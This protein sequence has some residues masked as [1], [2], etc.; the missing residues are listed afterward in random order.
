MMMMIII[1]IIIIIS[2]III[3][4]III[5]ILSNILTISGTT[6]DRV[7]TVRPIFLREVINPASLIIRY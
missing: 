3:I 2:I 4:I 1:I 5:I 7:L 6:E